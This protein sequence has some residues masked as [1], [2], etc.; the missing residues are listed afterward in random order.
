MRIRSYIYNAETAAEHVD[1][2][3]ERL[4]DRDESIDYLDIAAA[5]DRDDAIREAMLTVRE[6]VR[7]G[8]NPDEIYDEDGNPDFSAG[9]L[10]T[11]EP[12]GRRSL[13]VGEAA[14][15]ALEDEEG[16]E[17]EGDAAER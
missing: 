16:A 17:G 4:S 13:A 11:Q 7:I 14:L 8:T 1:P 3:L 10:V 15:E 12:T 2:V 9:V 6:S 5:D